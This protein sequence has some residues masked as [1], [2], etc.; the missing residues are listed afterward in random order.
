MKKQQQILLQ[1][2]IGAYI[3]SSTTQEITLA[4][5]GKGGLQEE[6]P[7][8]LRSQR[9]CNNLSTPEPVT[10]FNQVAV[11]SMDRG[12]NMFF[13]KKNLKIPLVV[14]AHQTM[15]VCNIFHHF[16]NNQI[17]DFYRLSIRH[18]NLQT[19]SL[20]FFFQ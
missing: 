8:L 14:F 10:V 19:T 12:I 2:K 3:D 17:P 15:S 5:M 6:R 1:I 20:P 4:K 16:D 13:T 9:R 18:M 11:I 7:G